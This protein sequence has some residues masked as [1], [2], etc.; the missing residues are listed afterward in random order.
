MS[1]RTRLTVSLLGT[2]LT[3]MGCAATNDYDLFEERAQAFYGAERP[4]AAPQAERDPA[5]PN[6]GVPRDLREPDLDA[7]VRFGLANNAGLRAA[8]EDWGA[9]TERVEQSATLPDPRV[10]FVESIEEVQT[11]TGPQQRRLGL[12]QAFPW[13]GAL[14]AR[15]GVAAHEAE[16]LWHA[17]QSERLRVQA[18]IEVAYYEYA[19]LA[20]E[21][22]ISR[23]LLEL[24]RGLEPVV[25]SRVRSGAGQADLLR[26]QV[27]VGRLED[28][29][30]SIERRRPVLSAR[31]AQALTLP[32]DDRELLPLPVLREPTVGAI[33]V[34]QSYTQALERSPELHALAERL[35]GAQAA[36]GAAEYRSKPE[37]SVMLDYIQTGAALT[38][39]TPG[40]GDDPFMIGVSMTLPIWGSSYSAAEREARHR[41]QATRQRIVAAESR[42]QA[43][44]EEHAFGADDAARRINL[45]RDSLI[46]RAEEALELT[47]AAYRTGAASIL[48]LID[49]ERALLEFE[50]SF[51][52]ACREHWQSTARLQALLG[53]VDQ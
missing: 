53:G 30:A 17:V 15:S 51:W 9:A 52:R 40:S 29:L 39:S 24:L 45:Y 2:A 4:A 27:E 19:F 31:L 33:D 23:E 44:L 47:L 22:E 42:I 26:L 11:R 10:T 3:V 35:R 46:P 34:A 16:A 18:E 21:Q 48:D 20:R 28:N 37:F 36:Q 50:L 49:S 13:P 8:F 41:W 43:E 1:K 14:D 32:P 38:P 7:Y 5:A 6:A 25:Q 12:S